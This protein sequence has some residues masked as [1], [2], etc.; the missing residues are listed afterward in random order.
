MKMFLISTVA[1][2][3]SGLAHA[4]Q[5][6]PAWIVKGFSQPESAL[7]VK[8]EN[9]IFVSN[10]VGDPALKDGHGFISRVSPDGK[11]QQLEWVS[12]LNA[13][14]GLGYIKGRLYVADIDRLVEIDVKTGRITKVLDAPGA[15]FL[16]DI[17]VDRFDSVYVSDMLDNAIWYFSDGEFDKV[18][19]DESLAFPNGLLIERDQLRIASWGV[20]TD[21]FATKVPG[22][23]KTVHIQETTT[24]A[25]RFGS[26]PLGNLDGLE[27][28]GQGG[29][30]VSDWLAG[31]VLRVNAKGEA[32]LFLQLSQ[33]TADLGVI[34]GRLLLVPLMNEGELRAYPISK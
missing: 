34:P 13:P 24:A 3:I 7:Y 20:M 16:N 9:S 23:L 8:A 26:T 30:F 25:D 5:A 21:G 31:K 33:G 29:Y 1:L 12:G 27:A 19:Q 11:L 15:K 10:I 4:G 28:D 14:K 2:L 22:R 18:M 32:S 6:A 17:A